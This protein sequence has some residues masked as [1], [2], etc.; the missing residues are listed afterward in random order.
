MYAYVRAFTR[1]LAPFS[2]SLSRRRA[3]TRTVYI[4]AYI[5]VYLNIFIS[6][7]ILHL[8]CLVCLPRLF[9]V[10]RVKVEPRRT[11]CALFIC[12]VTRVARVFFDID[13]DV[14]F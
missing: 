9:T 1:M 3:P 6:L 12:V 11:L 7:C 13:V 10:S 4:H 8:L 14:V 5:Y 2:L